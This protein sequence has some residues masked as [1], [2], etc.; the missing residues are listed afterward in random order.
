MFHSHL[1]LSVCIQALKYKI[2]KFIT[3]TNS[4]DMEKELMIFSARQNGMTRK[5]KVM[6]TVIETPLINTT[7]L[8]ETGEKF[9]PDRYNISKH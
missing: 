4:E 1:S 3:C 5:L 8:L 7:T 2:G 6:L 9:I